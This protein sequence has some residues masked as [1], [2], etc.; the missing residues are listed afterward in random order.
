MS[1][2]LEYQFLVGLLMAVLVLALAARRLHL[3]SAAALIGGGIALAFIPG[4][5]VVAMDP[6]IVMVVFMPPLLFSSAYQTVW[7]D[8]KQYFAAISSLAVGAVAFTTLAVGCVVHGLRPDI[9]WSAAFALGAIV[10]P[11]DAVAA[12]AVLEK[13]RLP[14]RVMTVLAGE[15]LVND[16]S[17]LVLF[18]FAVAA[19]LGGKFDVPTAIGNFFVVSIGGIMVGFCLGW[20]ALRL[21]RRFGNSELIVTGTL[22]LA[23][24]SYMASDQLGLSGVL[25]TV[26][27]A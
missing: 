17:G 23:A 24:V 14:N 9:P 10:S 25:A 1:I 8:F 3:P 2:E 20:I 5:P 15:S 4:I 6:D 7:L 13:L 27:P 26:R 21:L 12:K 16:A 11:P 22:L 18:H 19:A